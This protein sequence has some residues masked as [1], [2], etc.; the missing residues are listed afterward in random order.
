MVV[1]PK[2]INPVSVEY[3]SVKGGTDH[4]VQTMETRGDVKAGTVDPVRNAERGLEV[5]Y[6]L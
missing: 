6:A 5:L 2:V 3:Y 1:P 4:Y